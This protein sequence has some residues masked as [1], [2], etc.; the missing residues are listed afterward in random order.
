MTTV[1]LALPP[2]LVAAIDRQAAAV[3]LTRRAYVRTILAAVV[4]QAEADEI[5]APRVRPA[6]AQNDEAPTG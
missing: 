3:F 4:R 5:A 1:S 2:D 6:T